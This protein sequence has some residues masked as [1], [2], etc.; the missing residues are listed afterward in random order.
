MVANLSKHINSF[1]Y[2]SCNFNIFLP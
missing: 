1:P 2:S